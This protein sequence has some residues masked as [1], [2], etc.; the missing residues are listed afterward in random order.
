MLSNLP[1]IGKMFKFRDRTTT[2]TELVIFIRPVVMTHG[3]PK[4]NTQMV[5][6]RRRPT[7]RLGQY[8]APPATTASQYMQPQG[9]SSYLDFTNPGVAPTA[10]GP[11]TQPAAPA[12]QAPQANY[13]QAPGLMAPTAP[14]AAPYPQQGQAYGQQPH[15]PLNHRDRGKTGAIRLRLPALPSLMRLNRPRRHIRTTAVIVA[16]W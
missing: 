12:P 1:G 5:R 15:L 8:G 6:N 16:P 13:R 4:P 9:P 11:V 14:Q 3:A 7:P 10:P 2:K